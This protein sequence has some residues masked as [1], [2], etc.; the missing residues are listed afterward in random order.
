MLVPYYTQL[1]THIHR[2]ILI[3]SL[4]QHTHNTHTHTHTH[5]ERSTLLDSSHNN[6]KHD[7]YTKLNKCNKMLLLSFS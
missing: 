4:T 6:N 7:D 5:T 3:V 2:E 1:K